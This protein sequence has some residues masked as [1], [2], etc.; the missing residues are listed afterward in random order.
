[1]PT[2]LYLPPRDVQLLRET[3]ASMVRESPEFQRLMRT[4]SSPTKP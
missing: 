2:T 1:M 4:I 3:G